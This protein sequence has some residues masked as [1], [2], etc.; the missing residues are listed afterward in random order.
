V[1]TYAQKLQMS[2]GLW[3]PGVVEKPRYSNFGCRKIYA[4]IGFRLKRTSHGNI[5]IGFTFNPNRYKFQAARPALY[6]K[7][8]LDKVGGAGAVFGDAGSK[9]DQTHPLAS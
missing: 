6:P 1:I 4:P 8:A 7:L 5:N 2:S 9:S 3:I